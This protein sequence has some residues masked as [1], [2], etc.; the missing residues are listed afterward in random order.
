MQSELLSKMIYSVF[1]QGKADYV[2]QGSNSARDKASAPLFKY[3][4][5]DKLRSIATYASK[6]CISVA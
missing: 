1:S 3:V 4:N 6:Y 2:A 5:E